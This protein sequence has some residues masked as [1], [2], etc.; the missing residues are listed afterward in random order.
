MYGL[1]N[2]IQ[3][4]ELPHVLISKQ[5]VVPD[6]ISQNNAVKI[7][8]RWLSDIVFP[9]SVSS[10]YHVVYFILSWQVTSPGTLV[11]CM[12]SISV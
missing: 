5:N 2:Q 12:I 7:T 3:N 6:N 11:L 8:M 4:N 1:M 9:I 10:V